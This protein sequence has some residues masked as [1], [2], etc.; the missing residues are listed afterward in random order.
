MV[1]QSG[2]RVKVC[3]PVAWVRYDDGLAQEFPLGRLRLADFDPQVEQIY[4]QP[5]RLVARV[6]GR[7]RHHVPEHGAARSTQVGYGC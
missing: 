5:F 1:A 2:T 3:D 4:A 7:M 6:G